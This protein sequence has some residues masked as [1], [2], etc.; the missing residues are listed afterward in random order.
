MDPSYP[1]N[2][3][4]KT[5]ELR[6]GR[7]LGYVEVGDPK[8]KPVF[9]FHGTPGCRLDVLFAEKSALEK[10]IRFIGI[11][12]PGMGLSDFQRGRKLLNWPDDVSQLADALG[13]KRFAVQGVSGGGPFAL[14]CAY[15]IPDRLTASGIIVGMGPAYLSTKGMHAANRMIFLISK[16]MPS[17]T[18][19]M[20]RKSAKSTQDY[21]KSLASMREDL[22]KN[23]RKFDAD[24]LRPQEKLEIFALGAKEAF[25]QGARGIAVEASIFMKPWGFGLEDVTCKKIHLW[26]G[27][28]DTN[29]P[30][31]MA[32]HMAEKI[33]NCQAKYY[34]GEGHYSV[35]VNHLDE[36]IATLAAYD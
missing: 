11:D 8:G 19:W 15:K 14:A 25:R 3:P 23:F 33:P 1:S 27:D 12:R 17:L 7:K 34:E 16:Y 29:V 31:T 4:G 28:Q 2:P 26:H 10:G 22:D 21:A 24:A 32:R 5:I 35:P 36:I 13:L 20:M 30:I 6:D 18:A 9:H